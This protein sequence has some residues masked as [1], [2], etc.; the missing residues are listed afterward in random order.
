MKIPR[1]RLPNGR[2]RRVAMG[3]EAPEN[4]RTAPVMVKLPRWLMD[5]CREQPES[6]ALLIVDAL[7]AHR[8]PPVPRDVVEHY[9]R[10][11][12]DWRT[13]YAGVLQPGDLKEEIPGLETDQNGPISPGDWREDIPH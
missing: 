2:V 10:L 3:A 6:T 11:D 1:E 9:Q 13:K 7:L 8:R 12:K 4:A 5:W